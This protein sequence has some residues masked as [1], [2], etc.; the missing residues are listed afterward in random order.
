[1]D[2]NLMIP[3]TVAQRDLV[4]QGAATAGSDMATWARPILLAAA[5]RE[6]TKSKGKIADI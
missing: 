4:N 5:K 1:M 3:V 6:I 2:R